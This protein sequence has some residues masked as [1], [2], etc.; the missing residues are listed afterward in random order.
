MA[1]IMEVMEEFQKTPEVMTVHLDV[2]INFDRESAKFTLARGGVKHVVVVEP[3]I[4]GGWRFVVDGAA[5]APVLS[6]SEVAARLL[7]MQQEMDRAGLRGITDDPNRR[8]P[9]QEPVK[10]PSAPGRQALIDNL[11]GRLTAEVNRLREIADAEV[12]PGDA[13]ELRAAADELEN[14]WS[15][16]WTERLYSLRGGLWMPQWDELQ[17]LAAVLA[18]EG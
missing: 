6:A 12:N 1:S 11:H 4:S 9:K 17:M 5:A 7:Q 16:G 14:A 3:D 18:A 10:L 2:D 8:W 13:H 15:L